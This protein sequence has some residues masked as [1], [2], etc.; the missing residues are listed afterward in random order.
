MRAIQRLPFG[1]EAW[2]ARQRPAAAALWQLHLALHASASANV[3]EEAR[4]TCR[5]GGLPL[6][7]VSEQ[8]SAASR[9]APPARF[10]TS[11]DL[12]DFCRYFVGCHARLLGHL[13]GQTGSWQERP[14]QELA[15]ALFLTS[16]LFQLQEDLDLDRVF[17]PASDLEQ[18]GTPVE[19]LKRRRM[20]DAVRRLIW[21]ETVL[22]RNA[23]AY[24]RE[25]GGELS[26]WARREFRR[27]WL[28]GLYLVSAVE[29]RDYDVWSAAPALSLPRRVQ[30]W[31]QAS[32]GNNDDI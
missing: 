28:G 11:Q 23:Y 4:N 1:P 16:R 25:L 32:L 10:E 20:D 5:R 12:V 8:I 6:D 21:K 26:G 2:P 30:L 22:I 18:A 15:T 27:S 31:L 13:A 14:T 9:L 29:R 3:V 7:L 17:V 19:D 24:G